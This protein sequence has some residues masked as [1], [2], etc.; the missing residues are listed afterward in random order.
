ME[1]Y[2][3]KDSK[4]QKIIAYFQDHR[5]VVEQ[6][7]FFTKKGEKIVRSHVQI[8]L[9]HDQMI[10]L[11]KWWFAMTQFDKL[12]HMMDDENR[13][14]TIF[15]DGKESVNLRIVNDYVVDITQIRNGETS[16]LKINKRYFYAM[17]IKALYNDFR[18]DE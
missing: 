1:Q 16:V 12:P 10:L 6:E 7:Y 9:T 11:N 15:D 4:N 18:S 14:R 2:V 17:I 8:A 5:F 13:Q 3:I